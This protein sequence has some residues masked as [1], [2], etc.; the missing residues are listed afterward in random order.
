MTAVTRRQVLKTES[1]LNLQLEAGEPIKCN[2]SASQW[3]PGSVTPADSTSAERHQEQTSSV[4]GLSESSRVSD[5]SSI[6][7]AKSQNP[8]LWSHFSIS[9][10][11]G[12]LLY[13]KRGKRGPIE[14]REIRCTMCNWKTTD[15][16][17]AMS[18]SNMKLHLNRHGIPSPAAVMTVEGRRENEAAIGCYN[19]QEKC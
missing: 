6:P 11:P 4:E 7:L 18:T 15:S 8:S 16:A 19:V 17:R 10:L 14:D 2:D 9:Y 1:R 13:P 5:Q 3:T 12:K